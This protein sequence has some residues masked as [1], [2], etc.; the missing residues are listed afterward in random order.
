M[1]QEMLDVCTN[2]LALAKK[3]GA[4]EAKAR[5]TRM[6]TIEI[7]YRQRKPEKIKESTTQ[8]LSVEVYVDGRYSAQRS[9]D[10]RPKALADFVAN[11]VA[12]TRLIA[13]DPYRSL[14]DPRRY[15]GR[16]D[17]DL[18]ILD[19][20]FGAVTPD[21]RHRLV[22]AVEDAALAAGGDKV[23]S[24]TAGANDLLYEMA[25]ATSNGFSGEV[26][27]TE[28]SLGGQMTLQDAGDR[29]PNGYHYVTT[30]FHSQLPDPRAVGEEVARRTASLLGAKKI[31]TETLPIVV[32]NRVVPR[33]LYSLIDPLSAGSIQQKRSFLADKKGQP[34]ASTAF[35]LIDDAS[36]PG[37]LQSAPFDGDGFPS[38]RR[39]IV[40]K[41]VLKE[42]FVDW[43]YGRKLGWEPTTGGPTNVIIPPGPRAV[44]EIL[45]DLGRGIVITEFIGGNSNSTTGDASIGIGGYLF[46][47]GA[48]TQAV[49]EMNVADNQLKFWHKLVE[50]ANDP[51]PYSAFQTPSLVFKDVVV[52][53]V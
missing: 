26:R 27:A 46:E 38:R 16:S 32:E 45:K 1:G 2:A 35:T 53:G 29:R 52:S 37:G 7:E 43:Y 40:D 44:A 19:S 24:V 49:A 21:E 31:A 18:R 15:E 50:V 13:E 17:A 25:A 10:L 20:S 12:T 23:I 22:R 3:A 47:N 30:R 14:P 51:W 33:L 6:R 28:F 48:R 9:S 5:L 8:D 39:V 41:G 4:G 42:F 36:L 34:I 11:A